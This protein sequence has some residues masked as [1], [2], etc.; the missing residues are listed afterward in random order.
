MAPP[1]AHPAST[2]SRAS[3]GR[4]T[5]HDLGRFGGESLFDRI[6]PGGVRGRVP[7]A[8]GAVRSV[9]D[10]AAGAARCAAAAASSTSAAATGCSRTSCCCSTTPRRARSSSI[11]HCRP[12][13]GGCTRRS[14]PS[15]RGSPAACPSSVRHRRGGGRGERPHRVLP[16]LRAAHR[17]RPRPRHRRAGARRGPAVLPRPRLLRNGRAGWMD[18]GR[19]GDRRDA[20]GA[21]P[22]AGVSHLDEDDSGRGHAAQPAP[23]RGADRR[24][25]RT[26]RCGS[27]RRCPAYFGGVD[28]LDH[29]LA[30]APL[31]GGLHRDLGAGLVDGGFAG[32]HAPPSSA[33]S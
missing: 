17:R 5:A 20:G 31:A 13:T 22:P 11:R 30:R 8:Q 21:T 32:D 6:A 23:D 4:L 33:T 12:H 24:G 3:H 25:V 16:R 27:A 1:M 15:G 29:V 7:A 18:A 14:S 19:S 2:F 26:R 28:L 10:G 9:G